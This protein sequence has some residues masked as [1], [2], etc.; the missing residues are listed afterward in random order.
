MTLP[1]GFPDPRLVEAGNITFSVHEAGPTDGTP[2]LMLHGWPELAFSWAPMV[3][4]LT[5]A[6]CRLIM[7]DIKGF[8]GTSAP[9]DPG[10]YT[11]TK[12]AED[13]RLLIGALGLEKVVIVGHDWGGAIAWPLAQRLGDLA[14]GVAVYCTPYPAIAAASPIAIWEKRFGAKHYIVQF[15][16]ADLPDKAF[17]GREKDFFSLLLRKGPPR[18]IWPKILPELTYIPEQLDN[19]EPPFDDIVASDEALD[20]YAEV[21]AKTG[22]RGPTWVYRLVDTHWEERKA[23]NPDITIPA[24]MVTATRDVLLPAEASHGMEGWVTDL[25]RDEVDSGHWV[26]WEAPNEASTALLKWLRT[27]ELLPA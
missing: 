17:G 26:T 25:S 13:Y 24:L 10:E 27:T 22:H 4:A 14:L 19:A 3:D 1:H 9:D 21:Y 11:M 12:I 5:E 15:Q 8:G 2:L 18:E 6:G 20:H 7:P 16:D 23:F